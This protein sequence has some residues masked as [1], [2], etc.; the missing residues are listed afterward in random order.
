MTDQ[1]KT[2]YSGN[3]N[4]KK[5]QEKKAAEKK[6]EPIALEGSVVEKKRSVATKFKNLFFGGD[7]KTSAQYVA[8]EI[9]MPGMRNMVGD[10]AKGAVDRVLYGDRG[11]RDKRT[12]SD[13]GSRVSYNRPVNR[14]R[15]QDGRRAYLPDQAPHPYRT[16]TME[17]ND[18]VFSTR[19]DAEKVLTTMYDF[20]ESYDLVSLAD[21]YEMVGLPTK[22]TDTQWGWTELRA[23]SVTQRSNGYLIDLPPMITL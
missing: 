2:D 6:V 7:F 3:S 21:V 9:V 20:L 19:E 4:K 14:D 15:G 1:E 12:G 22:Y 5:E 23:S 17:I 16:N 13:Y 18:L 11:G 10:A 8:S